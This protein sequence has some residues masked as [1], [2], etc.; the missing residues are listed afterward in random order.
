[1]P[2]A[3]LLSESGDVQSTILSSHLA[4]GISRDEAFDPT[5]VEI[6]TRDAAQLALLSDGVLEAVNSANEEFGL[7][8]AQKAL[9]SAPARDRIE[10]LLAAVF[11]YQR[12]TPQVDDMAVA[13]LNLRAAWWSASPLAPF[14]S[15]QLHNT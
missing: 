1:M 11:A 4:L 15:R 6:D 13:M 3:L 10:A 14:H 9:G 2:N 5:T 8:R 12:P 7:A